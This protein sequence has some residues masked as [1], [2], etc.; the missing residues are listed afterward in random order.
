MRRPA[1]V[2]FDVGD[3][4]LRETRFDLDAGIR[5]VLPDDETLVA[6]LSTRFRD[7]SRRLHAGRRDGLLSSWLR[8]NVPSLEARTDESL[9]NDLW[10][11][12]VT[13]LPTRGIA[14]LLDRLHHDGIAT[15]AVSNASFSGRILLR[16]LTRHGLG[17]ELS[18]VLSS[19][20]LKIRKPAAAIFHEAL[21]RLGQSA[22]ATWY[23][24]DTFD[25]DIEGALG[26]GLEPIWLHDGPVAARLG[27]A[28]SIVRDWAEFTSLYDSSD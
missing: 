27:R 8:E 13:L 10:G 22:H 2:L 24:G 26:V 12:I 3:T 7:E 19:G 6:E 21:C 18:F 9:E 20:D 25:E 28:V 14:A 4:L 5:A 11:P 16:E 1:A 23:V 15:A 17:N